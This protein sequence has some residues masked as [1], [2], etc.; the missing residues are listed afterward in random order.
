MATALKQP[1]ETT[2]QAGKADPEPNAMAV[3]TPYNLE[4]QRS[5]ELN[6]SSASPTQVDTAPHLRGGD[7][8]ASAAAFACCCVL[9]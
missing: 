1:A 6:Y 7:G 8:G 4:V 2:K 9:M 5:V 3:T